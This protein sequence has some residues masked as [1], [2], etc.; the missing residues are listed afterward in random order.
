MQLDLI[1]CVENIK[2]PYSKALSPLYEAII[3]SFQAIED[4]D[5]KDDTYIKISITRDNAQ[6]DNSLTYSIRVE[7]LLVGRR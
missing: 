6:M 3:N 2:L 4:L 5:E 7:T 1:G